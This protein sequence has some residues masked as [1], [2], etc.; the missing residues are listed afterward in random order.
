MAGSILLI[1]VIII[2]CI[3][4]MYYAIRHTIQE[5]A[6]K[7]SNDFIDKYVTF[8]RFNQVEG[9]LTVQG[10][11]IRTYQLGAIKV[12]GCILV[13][14]IDCVTTNNVTVTDIVYQGYSLFS[15]APKGIS[16]REK[17]DYALEVLKEMA[18]QGKIK[19]ELYTEIK[20]IVSEVDTL[21]ELINSGHIYKKSND[22]YTWIAG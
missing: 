17:A 21:N 7:K 22:D 12:D 20:T 9:M 1:P 14:F 19:S 18:Q 10:R 4:M 2:G 15:Y 8:E 6:I 5:K 3:M 11:K 13:D 16:Y